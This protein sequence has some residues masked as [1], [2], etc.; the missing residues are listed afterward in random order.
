MSVDFSYL[1]TS[2]EQDGLLRES[3]REQARLVEREERTIS[4]SLNRIQALDHDN[5]QSSAL[6]PESLAFE[7]SAWHN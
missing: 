7:S 2:L 4:A 1:A 5:S 3:I 6:A